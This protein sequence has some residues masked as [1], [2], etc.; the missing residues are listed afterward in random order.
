MNLLRNQY[1]ALCPAPYSP[2]LPLLLGLVLCVVTTL[3][4]CKGGTESDITTAF[5]GQSAPELTL[6]LFDGSDYDL[7]EKR[8][9][10]VV[11]NFYASW[12]I[13]CKE[14]A[15]G[16][17]RSFREFGPRGV[18]FIAI[19]V[20]DTEVKAREFVDAHKLTFPTG[21]DN[22]GEIEEAFM[23]FGLPTTYIIDGNG[24]IRYTHIGGITGVV[25]EDELNK[26][27]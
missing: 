13:P 22:S 17:E 11:L 9:S 27:L 15:P 7:S 18:E 5:E 26:L 14:E 25:I 8:G 20:Q 6:T 10:P 1:P 21:F 24:I 4:G 16:L 2:L 19:A 23:V 12:C 3:Q